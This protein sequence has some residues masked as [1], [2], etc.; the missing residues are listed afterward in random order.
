[1]KKEITDK[2][3]TLNAKLPL[4]LALDEHGQP[5]D[6]ITY[7]D[8]AYYY[9]QEKV[10]WT[11][12]END[13]ILRG[14]TNGLT[15]QQSTMQVG[16]VIAI[17]GGTGKGAHRRPRLTKRS[18]FRRD[19]FKCAYCGNHFHEDS[20]EMEHVIPESRNGAT[21]WENLVTACRR[22]NGAKGNRTPDEAGMPLLYKPYVPSR[23][24]Y[25]RFMNRSILTCQRQ[26][27]DDYIGKKRPGR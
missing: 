11:P 20:L 4:V 15:G 3:K 17:K 1:M 25:L 7:E 5:T 21:I 2:P 10:A 8:A 9:A 24:E 27:L 6:W 14:G 18:L 19:E 12:T 16:T 13:F 22:C 26:F 23:A